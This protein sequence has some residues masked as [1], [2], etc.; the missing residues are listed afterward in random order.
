MNK[1]NP[2][3]LIVLLTVFS[4][5]ACK[6]NV[7]QLPSPS[8]N[9][10][11]FEDLVIPEGFTWSTLNR[12]TFDVKI[13]DQNGGQSTNLDGF[14]LDVTDPAGNRLQRVSVINGVASFYL[15]LNQAITKINLFA[16][17]LNISQEADIANENMVFEI[18]PLQKATKKFTDSDGDG[19]YDEFDD[20]QDDPTRTYLTYYPSPYDNSNFKSANETVVVNYWQMFEDLWPAKGDY[21]LNDLVLKLRV[22]IYNNASNQWVGGKWDVTIW[23]NGA[24]T[25]LGCGIEFFNYMGTNSGK[26]RF[27]YLE[28][29]QIALVPGAY[30]AAIT[31]LDPD[32]QNGVILFN[33]VDDAKPTDYWNTGAGISHEPIT[34]SFEYTLANEQNMMA[35]FLYL[36]RTSDRGHE[37]RTFGIPPTTAANTALLGT[38]HDNSPLTLWDYT[39]GT[40]FLYPLDPPYY[41]TEN[42]HPWGVEIEYAGDLRVALEKTSIIDAFPDFA[43]WA[44]SGGTI[45]NTWYS[46]PDI[47]KTFDVGAL[48]DA[49]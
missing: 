2:I 26:Y 21:D 44:E 11:Q 14:P 9:N 4:V 12:T 31:S 22:E 46:N 8:E 33:N 5:V 24:S 19:V 48:I 27:R 10:K 47:S 20:F 16:P 37:V 3:F 40:E 7:E 17:S 6:K 15:E 25:N 1:P 30:N 34:V 13:V 28:N 38:N 35:G 29:D 49:N 39:P 41:S 18:P 32:V 23:A 45:N 42:L 36:F 43:A